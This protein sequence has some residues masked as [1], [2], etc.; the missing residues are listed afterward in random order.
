LH[1]SA[2]RQLGLLKEIVATN[3]RSPELPYKVTFVATYHCNFR[4]QMCNI[5]QKKSVDEMTPSE[6]ALFFERWSQFRWVHLTGGELFMRRDLD[7]LVAAIQQSCRSLFLLNFPTTGWFGDRTVQLVERTLARGVGRLMVTI[8]LDGPKALHEE[9][10]GLPGSWDRAVETFRRLRGI[11]RSNFQTVVGMTLLGKNADQVDT[12]I[13]AIRTVIPDFRRTELHLNIGHESGHYFDNVGRA[14]L[15]PD[16][17]RV[18][19]AV[20]DH[21]RKNGTGLH[22]VHFLENRYQ[23]LVPAYYETGRSPLPC[24]ALSTS[25]FVDAY[26]NLFACSI[27]DAKIGNLRES[28]FDLAQLWKSAQRRQLRQD[29][30]EENCPHCWTPCEAYPTLLSSLARAVVGPSTGRGTPVSAEVSGTP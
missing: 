17:A 27:W 21:R 13:E 22:P 10:R 23:A 29:V 4:C 9:M 8:S 18:I 6:V 26:W 11:R 7:D 16:H 24:S 3:V 1:L 19:H 15:S 20:D 28:A 25:C 5:W 2:L 30:V 12:T 14:P